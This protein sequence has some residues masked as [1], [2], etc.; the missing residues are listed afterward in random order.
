[1]KIKVD[2]IGVNLIYNDG[3]YG[4][5]KYYGENYFKL[6]DMANIDA[7]IINREFLNYKDI[8]GNYYHLF[9]FYNYRIGF[10]YTGNEI[11]MSSETFFF[12][13]E[14]YYGIAVDNTLMNINF[15]M[16]SYE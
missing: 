10:I 12:C 4:I 6:I 14:D 13:E 3:K 8:N 16:K 2:N 1:M 5:V 11:E 9:N 7:T 15:L